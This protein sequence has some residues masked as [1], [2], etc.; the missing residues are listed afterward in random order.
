[1]VR[2]TRHPPQTKM[3]VS[4]RVS[5]SM[6]FFYSPGEVE[7]ELFESLLVGCYSRIVKV[8]Y[9]SCKSVN[10]N[11]DSAVAVNGCLCV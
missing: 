5:V 1:M 10:L 6:F 4:S 3:L 2:G 8:S 9:E 11:L 7:E